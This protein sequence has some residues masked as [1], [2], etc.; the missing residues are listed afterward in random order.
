[1]SVTYDGE[2]TICLSFSNGSKQFEKEIKLPIVL[3][4][5]VYKPEKNYEQ[6]DGVTYAGSFWISQTDN[7][8]TKPGSGKEWRLSVKRGKDGKNITAGVS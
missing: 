3:D 7:P 5:G 2:R 6:G 4:R 8:D 1:M